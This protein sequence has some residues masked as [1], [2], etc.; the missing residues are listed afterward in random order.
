[1]LELLIA[2]TVVEIVLALGVV[3]VYLTL[4]LRSL[5]S[6][7]RLAAKIS[8]G[9]RAIEAQAGQ[10][11]PAVVDLNGSLGAIAE[12]LPG[13]TGKAERLASAQG[14]EHP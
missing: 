6:S 3:A 11:G 13:V 2:L 7:A 9:V 4:V 1:M 10:I 5:R 14:G 8:F 12:A